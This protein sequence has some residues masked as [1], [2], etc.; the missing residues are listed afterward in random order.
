MRLLL[1]SVLV[2]I[3]SGGCSSPKTTYYTL[4]AAPIPQSSAATQNVRFMVGPVSLPE[5]V[6]QPHLVVN[7]GNNEMEVFKYDRW[8][9]SLKADVSRVIAA[10]L[11]REL[12]I[13]NIWSFSQSTQ[14]NFDYQIIIDVQ[15][16]HSKPGSSVFVD[17]LWSIK[18]KNPDTTSDLRFKPK[19][20]TGRSSVHEPVTQSG[21]DALVA[22]Q[23]RAFARVSGDI[24]SSIR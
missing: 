5:S 11:A 23:S 3:L 9:G 13:S 8:A 18:V 1:T 21:F 24:A 19:V 16:L 7:S 2:A 22:A 10:N 20:L 15:N 14:T 4:S 12:D 6:D 17:V